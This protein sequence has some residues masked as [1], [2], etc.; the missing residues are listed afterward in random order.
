MTQHARKMLKGGYQDNTKLIPSHPL[1]VRRSN[2]HS[3]AIHNCIVNS[4]V[5]QLFEADLTDTVMKQLEDR[6]FDASLS[7]G[8]VT[9][10][11]VRL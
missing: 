4:I 7:A 10:H 1:Q 2:A 6:V 9:G 11:G 8:M 5:Q 3:F